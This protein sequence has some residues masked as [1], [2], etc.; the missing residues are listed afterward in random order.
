MARLAPIAIVLVA[1]A[2]AACGENQV[3]R[4][5]SPPRGDEVSTPESAADM[6]ETEKERQQDIE[7]RMQERQIERFDEAEK[8]QP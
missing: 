6:A 2:L 3:E 5:L 1:L 8:S 4:G 7:Q